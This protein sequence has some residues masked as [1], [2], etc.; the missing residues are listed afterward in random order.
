MAPL[1][2]T[3]TNTP[4]PHPPSHHQAVH[5]DQDAYNP[6]RSPAWTV[7]S[8]VQEAAVE[9]VL[10]RVV[11][12]YCDCAT[13]WT[14]GPHTPAVPSPYPYEVIVHGACS[15]GATRGM[16]GDVVTHLDAFDAAAHL[17]TSARDTAATLLARTE[18][19]ACYD[20]LAQVAELGTDPSP[21]EIAAL[22]DFAAELTAALNRLM[23]AE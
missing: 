22:R 11:T 12:R 17:A 4:E 6:A 2:T 1:E 23:D 19:T 8:A 14:A 16:E 21:A 3:M 9:L 20:L 7:A 15:C 10:G 13:A 5:T 18:H